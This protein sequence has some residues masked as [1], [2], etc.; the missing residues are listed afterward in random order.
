MVINSLFIRGLNNATNGRLEK[1]TDGTIIR[2]TKVLFFIREFFEKTN[3]VTIY[4]NDDSTEIIFEE[5]KKYFASA[6]LEGNTIVLSPKDYL[7]YYNQKKAI[8]TRI[9]HETVVEHSGDE[10]I[11]SFTNTYKE[12]VWDSKIRDMLYDCP[13]CMST[14]YGNLFYY[15]FWIFIAKQNFSIELFMFSLGYWFALS[16]LNVLI[17]KK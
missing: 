1:L 6:V 5:L 9:K 2:K 8:E 10:Y 12:Y 17:E 15:T 11:L 3:S 14:I 4:S 16:Y 7:E 13:A